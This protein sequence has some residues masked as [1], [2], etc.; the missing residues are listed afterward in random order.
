M[1]RA[2]VLEMLR[3]HRPVLAERFGVADLALFG[4]YAR[5]E[6]TDGSDVDILVRFDAPPNWR[7][8][9]E[10][11]STWKTCC[12]DRWN[13]RPGRT[14]GPKCVRTSN[15]RP[16]MCETHEEGRRWDLYVGT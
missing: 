10:P 13:W 15:G 4:S 16:W 14:F 12:N 11:S 9:S 6:G 2:E 8:T 3:A 1:T 5:D 7:P